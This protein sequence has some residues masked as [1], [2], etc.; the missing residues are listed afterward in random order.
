MLLANIATLLISERQKNSFIR[1]G[2]PV[3]AELGYFLTNQCRVPSNC[4]HCT[5]GLSLLLRSY[6][7]Y[8]FGLPSGTSPLSSRVQ[9]LRFAQEC[10]ATLKTALAD[11]ELFPCR[12]RQTLGFHLERLRSQ[13]EGYLSTKM[14]DLYFQSP[15]VCGSQMLE[16]GQAM[17]YYGLRL[18]AYTSYVGTVVHIYNVL[19][20]MND[21]AS[22]PLLDAY[23]DQDLSELFFPGGKPTK[24]F[25]T[26]YI[27]YQGGRLS[28]HKSRESNHQNGCHEL[29]IPDHTWKAT[30][31]LS[32]GEEIEGDARF[33]CA[34]WS[35][36]FRARQQDYR[37][38][39][40][41][42]VTTSSR[43][44]ASPESGCRSSHDTQKHKGLTERFA[45]MKDTVDRELRSHF[46]V[47]KLNHFTMLASCARVIHRLY[48]KTH[49]H[50]KPRKLC[51]CFA[52]DLFSAADGCREGKGWR[53]RKDVRELVESCHA[54]IIEELGEGNIEDCVFKML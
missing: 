24:R 33:D 45:E 31:G 15:W 42:G 9:A 41:N 19:R 2:S 51:Y 48:D 35:N 43:K 5:S 26:S 47:A 54:S 8:S 10:Q 40:W 25:H 14:F 53:V 13:F 36:L 32:H 29:V 49:D 20:Q 28:F 38:D 46:P 37:C 23:C 16:M 3:Y 22:I 12:C 1:H 17:N 39:H 18:L 50:K 11:E 30:V 44:R 34:R 7:F 52:Q 6:K 27:R 21:F 4:L